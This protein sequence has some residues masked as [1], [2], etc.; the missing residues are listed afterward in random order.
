MTLDLNMADLG[1]DAVLSGATN[2]RTVL[3]EMLKAT[4]KEPPAVTPVLLNFGMVEVATASFLRES[5][6]AF[7][8][9]IRGRRSN[10]YPVVANPNVDV[11][12]ELED[13]LSRRG[14]V[15]MACVTKDGAVVEA[16][17]IGELDPKQRLTFELVQQ[18]RETDAG[19][20]MRDH[21]DTERVKSPTAWNNRLANLAS[22][23][24]VAEISQGRSKRYKPIFEG[25]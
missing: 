2:G 25:V 17:L 13:L 8:D 14:G 18:R 24:L 21:A 16:A 5:V 19:E 22:L 10:F 3:A 15:L 4:A 20:L 6:L 1:R 12:E 23:G 9:A 7:R 11:R